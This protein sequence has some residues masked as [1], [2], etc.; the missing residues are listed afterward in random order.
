LQAGFRPTGMAVAPDGSIYF[1]DWVDKS[2][3]VHGQGRIWRLTVPA[4]ATAAMPPA[5][6]DGPRASTPALAD[7]MSSHRMVQDLLAQPI[8]AAQQMLGAR[9][10]H[11]RLSALQALRF[12]DAQ[13][14][15]GTASLLRDALADSHPA[16]RL[17]AVRWIA[18]ERLVALRDE[19]ASLLDGEMSDERYLL[20]VLAA[21]DWLDGEATP[22]SSGISDDILQRELAN[23]NRPSDLHALA[24]RLI[25]PNHPWLTV[26][27]LRA[28]LR[29]PA[30]SLQREAVW[31]LVL[32]DRPDARAALA[33]VVADESLAPELRADALVGLADDMPA[34]AV[35]LEELAAGEASATVAAPLRSPWRRCSAAP[36][37]YLSRRSWRHACHRGRATGVAL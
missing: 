35:L 28:L 23:A 7:P 21:I 17:Y 36:P 16:V 5:E 6:N 12:R 25:S 18:D 11:L 8:E 1:A 20:C 19:V 10:P 15:A 3:A 9:E 13:D 33:D 27:R 22:R 30:A 4:A 31:T 24:L 34:H 29:S 14:A 2:Y 32:Q 26:E 37:R